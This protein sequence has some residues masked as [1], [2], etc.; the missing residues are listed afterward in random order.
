LISQGCT[1]EEA[2]RLVKEKRPAARPEDGHYKKAI[3][4]F[5]RVMQSF[6]YDR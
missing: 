2:M 3:E 5:E 6:I 4:N 1:A